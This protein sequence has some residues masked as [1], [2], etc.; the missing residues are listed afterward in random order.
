MRKNS[1]AVFQSGH[2]CGLNSEKY[3][4]DEVAYSYTKYNF[5]RIGNRYVFFT[6]TESTELYSLALHSPIFT[7]LRLTVRK[8]PN[9]ALW[10]KN[11]CRL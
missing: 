3:L 1:L 2:N 10:K 11:D 8:N 4:A 6:S 5:F 9:T 7:I